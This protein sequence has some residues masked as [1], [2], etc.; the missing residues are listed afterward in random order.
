MTSRCAC[1]AP[2]GPGK[3]RC[4]ECIASCL[5]MN[6]LPDEFYDDLDEQTDPR[7]ELPEEEELPETLR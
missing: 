2:I 3:S 7:F 5:G 1:G 4:A 6:A